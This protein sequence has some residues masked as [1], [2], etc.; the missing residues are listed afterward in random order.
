[1][2]IVPCLIVANFLWT[3][4]GLDEFQRTAVKQLLFSCVLIV[5][6]LLGI[7]QVAQGVDVRGRWGG[8]HVLFCIE[9]VGRRELV[10]FGIVGLSY[11]LDRVFAGQ[12][13]NIVILTPFTKFG[14]P[15]PAHLWV[16]A[17]A[18]PTF[19]VFLLILLDI[20][21]QLADN[22]LFGLFLMPFH[23][24]TVVV[25]GIMPICGCVH[26]HIRWLL[27]LLVGIDVVFVWSLVVW[28]L[29]RWN[30]VYVAFR[31]LVFCMASILFLYTALCLLSSVVFLFLLSCIFHLSLLRSFS[32][33]VLNRSYGPHNL[34][35]IE[36]WLT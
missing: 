32:H 34:A 19:P 2:Q 7:D 30:Y 23:P 28:L 22:G 5:V 20:L 21:F 9:T 11:R 25:V 12:L 1:M 29:G 26:A 14:F 4:L 10:R 15:T 24:C 18:K 35:G 31:C 3:G 16:S 33:R 8:I 27:S 17:L 6:Q 36:V 13:W